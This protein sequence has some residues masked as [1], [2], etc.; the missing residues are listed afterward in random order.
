MVQ[1]GIQSIH[2]E[3]VQVTP[4]S[5]STGKWSYRS[6]RYH[7]GSSCLTWRSCLGP[8]WP[9]I[10]SPSIPALHYHIRQASHGQ[11]LGNSS[12]F[13]IFSL[14][15]GANCTMIS[16]DFM[17]PTVGGGQRWDVL[18]YDLH[19]IFTFP[20]ESCIFPCAH[21]QPCCRHHPHT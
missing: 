19:L 14:G 7:V 16:C 3:V 12:K 9:T 13:M 18:L 4:L 2:E 1:H 11:Y 10:P 5:V 6:P 20:S 21:L 8:G 15:L 17:T